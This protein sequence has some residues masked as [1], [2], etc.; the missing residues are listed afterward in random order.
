MSRFRYIVTTVDAD[1]GVTVI[2]LPILS[3]RRAI[4]VTPASASP[5]RRSWPGVRVAQMLVFGESFW[6]QFLKNW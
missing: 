3:Y 6:L 1:A 2:A 5:R 4:T